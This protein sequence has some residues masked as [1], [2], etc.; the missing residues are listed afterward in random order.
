MTLGLGWVWGQGGIAWELM[1]HLW[2][3]RGHCGGDE[4]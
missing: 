4:S 2:P 3:Y 1:C